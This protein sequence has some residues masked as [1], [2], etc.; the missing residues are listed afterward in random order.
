MFGENV[1]VILTSGQ[2]VLFF[3]PRLQ[4]H[5]LDTEIGLNLLFCLGKGE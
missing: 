3:P 2:M 1:I 4:K 5:K